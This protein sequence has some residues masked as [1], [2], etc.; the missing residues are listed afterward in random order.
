MKNQ[1]KGRIESLKGAEKKEDALRKALRA[2]FPKTSDEE[3]NA[4]TRNLLSIIQQFKIDEKTTAKD[5]DTYA[6][7]VADVYSEQ[8]RNAKLS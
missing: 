7:I 1:A 8:W 4:A 5:F 6:Q 2:E 3:L